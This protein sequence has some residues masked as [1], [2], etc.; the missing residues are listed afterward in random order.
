MKPNTEPSSLEQD[1]KIIT[2]KN[3]G[4]A[5]RKYKREMLQTFKYTEEQIKRIYGNKSKKK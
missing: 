5:K 4:S 2:I 3:T 1:L